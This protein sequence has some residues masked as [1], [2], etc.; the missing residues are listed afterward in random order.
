MRGGVKAELGV[1]AEI[2]DTDKLVELRSGTC[3]T[4]STVTVIRGALGVV[5]LNSIDQ[6]EVKTLNGH[7]TPPFLARLVLKQVLW[8][9]AGQGVEYPQSAYLSQYLSANCATAGFVISKCDK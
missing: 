2:T 7:Q 9:Q 6:L 1:L 3:H 8:G 4:V 5:T